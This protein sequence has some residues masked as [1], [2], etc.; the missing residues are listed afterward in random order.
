MTVGFVKKK[1]YVT[2]GEFLLM[3]LPFRFFKLQHY[4]NRKN[5]VFP[6]KN[7]GLI[8]MRYSP[9]VKHIFIDKS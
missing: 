3:V 6:K 9:S 5:F 8:D 1:G 4:L 7:I 2:A